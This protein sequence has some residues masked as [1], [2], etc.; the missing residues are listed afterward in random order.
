MTITRFNDQIIAHEGF[1]LAKM[2][3]GERGCIGCVFLSGEEP[4]CNEHA[5]YS[6]ALPDDHPLRGAAW[7][8]WIRKEVA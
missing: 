5:C 2:P 7:I 6:G 4:G 3:E 8:Y 1:E